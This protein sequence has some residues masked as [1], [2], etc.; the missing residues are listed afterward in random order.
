MYV[1]K[2]VFGLDERYL[3]TDPDP[4]IGQMLIDEI[5]MTGNF[6]H[7]DSRFG[8]LKK[9]SRIIRLFTLLKKNLRFWRYSPGEVIFAFLFR[10][11]QPFWRLW[12]NLSYK[13]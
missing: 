10:V 1:L 8:D 6:G 13:N 5:M 2:L 12:A 11:G 9:S 7:Q 3:L 4:K